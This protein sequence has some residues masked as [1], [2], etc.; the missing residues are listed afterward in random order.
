MVYTYKIKSRG[1]IKTILIRLLWIYIQI[2]YD[3]LFKNIIN[4]WLNYLMIKNRLKA[5]VFNHCWS[6]YTSCNFGSLADVI[7][8]FR[9]RKAPNRN[10]S[11]GHVVL[12]GQWDSRISICTRIFSDK[13]RKTFHQQPPYWLPESDLYFVFYSLNCRWICIVDDYLSSPFSVYVLVD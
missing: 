2:K 1:L 11:F 12:L 5:R 13:R 3:T 9:Q 10:P 4:M 6:N 8:S 7:I